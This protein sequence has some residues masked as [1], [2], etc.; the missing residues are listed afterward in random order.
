MRGLARQLSSG[1][2]LGLGA[3]IYAISYAALARWRSIRVNREQPV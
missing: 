2:I 3:V 1:L